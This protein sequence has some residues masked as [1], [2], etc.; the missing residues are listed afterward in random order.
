MNAEE[1]E[2]RGRRIK[3]QVMERLDLSRELSDEEVLDV[4][5]EAVRRI[6]HSFARMI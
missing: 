2:E 4:I 5:D 1:L 3:E 6:K